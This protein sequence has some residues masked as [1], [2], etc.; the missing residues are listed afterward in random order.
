[1]TIGI[2]LPVT[3]QSIPVKYN[4]IGM[5]IPSTMGKQLVNFITC[6]CESSAP[7]FVSYTVGREFE[8]KQT[9]PRNQ[10]RY[11]KKNLVC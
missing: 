1:M 6:G 2:I 10:S 9:I 5:C 7:F 3:I 4:N 8:K 11:T